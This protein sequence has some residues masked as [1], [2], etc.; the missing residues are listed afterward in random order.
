MSASHVPNLRYAAM[1]LGLM[2]GGV[3]YSQDAPPPATRP[4]GEVVRVLRS[5]PMEGG[6]S[7]ADMANAHGAMQHPAWRA[8][9]NGGLGTRVVARIDEVDAQ[10]RTTPVQRHVLH[11]ASID[12]QGARVDLYPVRPDGTVA[13]STQEFIQAQSNRLTV[14]LARRSDRMVYWRRY[15]ARVAFESGGSE[16]EQQPGSARRSNRR[17]AESIEIRDP[18]EALP[19]EFDCAIIETAHLDLDDDPGASD[20]P[21]KAGAGTNVIVYRSYHNVE[22]PGWEVILETY[23]GRLDENG[24]PADLQL[25]TRWRIERILR[26]ADA[27]PTAEELRQGLRPQ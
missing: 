6:R 12:R 1:A 8:W 22:A 3:A 4:A 17:R 2:L 5:A 19:A 13:E 21:T 18:S 20:D 16:P 26:P 15:E 14:V 11:L 27:D 23:R 25:A 9:G 24:V 7:A 10:G